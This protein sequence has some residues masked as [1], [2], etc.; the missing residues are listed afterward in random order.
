MRDDELEQF[1]EAGRAT[2]PVP[3]A[4]LLERVLADAQAPRLTAAG[5]RIW[6]GLLAALGGWPA[7]AGLAS[8]T[9]A[10]IWLGYA[11]PGGLDG[12]TAALWPAQ[13]GYDVVD[14][15]PSYDGLLEEG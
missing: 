14:M 7:V 3:S 9:V 12:V 6:A 13:D 10:G 5:R 15:I 4:A 2:A 1:F 8:V 11:A